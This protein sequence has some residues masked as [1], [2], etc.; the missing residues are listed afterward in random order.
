MDTKIVEKFQQGIFVPMTNIQEYSINV[1]TRYL[2]TLSAK[3]LLAFYERYKTNHV[4]QKILLETRLDNFMRRGDEEW[5]EALKDLNVTI[6]ND[7][8]C[9]ACISC[10]NNSSRIRFG[11]YYNDERISDDPDDYECDEDYRDALAAIDIG[12]QHSED[13]CYA[14]L[15]MYDSIENIRFINSREIDM[16]WQGSVE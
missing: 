7:D 10:N 2:Y 6:K 9:G 12:R 5:D 4:I 15:D 8:I 3:D 14:C 13:I 1:L 16:E 11:Y